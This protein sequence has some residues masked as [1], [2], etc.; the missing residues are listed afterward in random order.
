VD[1]APAGQR[2]DR[3]RWVRLSLGPLLLLWILASIDRGALLRALLGADPLLLLVAYV[4]VL[5]TVPLRAYRWGLLGAEVT[6]ESAG[7][8]LSAYA[9]ALFVGVATPGRLGELV[10]AVYLS[11]KG[12]SWGAAL[13]SVL[14]DRLLDVAFLLLFA[15]FGLSLLALPLASGIATPVFAVVVVA[16]VALAFYATRPAP[17]AFVLR[18]LGALSPARFRARIDALPG[19]FF[20]GIQRVSARALA[21][22]C[23][24]TAL[25]WLLTYA[26]NYLLALGLGM[27]LSFGQIAAIS[28]V[29]SLIALLPIS[30]LGAGTRDAALIVI[31]A[32]YGYDAS[33]AVAFSTLL[34]SLSLWTGLA[35]APSLLTEAARVHRNP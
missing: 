17:A 25:A 1:E 24:L 21:L 26:S 18:V 2:K 22:C 15:A 35:C 32:R 4:T 9:Y 23:G 16:G 5:P 34:L 33:Q 28:A 31:L 11:R 3:L 14:L 7:S 19:D 6:G 30:V 27:T 29:C 10:K 12:L 8:R 13:S 20:A